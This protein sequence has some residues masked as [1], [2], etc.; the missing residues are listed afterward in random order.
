VRISSYFE[1]ASTP[2][3]AGLLPAKSIESFNPFWKQIII[4]AKYVKGLKKYR[5]SDGGVHKII[6]F[7]FYN[8]LFPCR[9]R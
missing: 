4:T 8:D 6:D 9:G 2:G 5:E 7:Y 3:V 1:V